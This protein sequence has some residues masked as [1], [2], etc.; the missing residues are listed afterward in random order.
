MNPGESISFD[1]SFDA[2]D[3]NFTF[4]LEFPT[5]DPRAMGGIYALTVIGEHAPLIAIERPLGVQ[6]ANGTIDDVGQ[7][8]AG[9]SQV[10]SYTILNPGTE[11]LLLTDAPASVSII[12]TDNATALVTMQPEL[13]VI[14]PS[15][16]ASFEVLYSATT[17]A[18]FQFDI[19][20]GNNVSGAG[21]VHRHRVWHR[22]RRHSRRRTHGPGRRSRRPGR[23][24]GRRH[25]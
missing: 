15:G 22:R 8:P 4:L 5:D 6:I 9:M 25:P 3:E 18:D 11:E 1:V 20:I 12:S 24:P 16:S 13:S 14:P 7:Q 23:R 17:Q 19:I 21:S 10:L 2:T